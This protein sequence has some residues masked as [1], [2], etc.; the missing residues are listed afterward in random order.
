MH[1]AM[2][3]KALNMLQ[4]NTVYIFL[5]NV[6]QKNFAIDN[7]YA[8]YQVYLS[9]RFCLFVFFLKKNVT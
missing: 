8:E 1:F 4:K 9:S 7:S 6:N 3:D 2:N 5:M